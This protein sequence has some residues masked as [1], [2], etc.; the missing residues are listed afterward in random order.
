MTAGSVN[1]SGDRARTRHPVPRTTALSSTP[2]APPVPVLTCFDVREISAAALE[3]LTGDER[4]RAAA[5]PESRR[6]CFVAARAVLRRL[7]AEHGIDP[8]VPLQYGAHGKPRLPGGAVLRFSISHT[9]ETAC[10]AT[11]LG[12]E[13]GVD[14]ERCEGADDAAALMRRFFSAREAAALDAL[15]PAERGRAFYETW[16]RREAVL[17][18]LGLGLGPDAES[19]AVSVPPAPPALTAAADARFA[20]PFALHPIAAGEGIVGTLAIAAPG[21]PAPAVIDVANL[22]LSPRRSTCRRDRGP[23]LER[24][25][26]VA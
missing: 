18:A 10:V 14:I 19:F 9:G 1:E 20:I 13:I 15:G 25:G 7:F 3:S 4:A 26:T 23:V 22:M 24:A 12:A 5:M 11:S 6:R 21:A 16:T 8:S 2:I 17:K